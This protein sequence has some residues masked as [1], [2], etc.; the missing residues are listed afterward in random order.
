MPTPPKHRQAIVTAAA[1]L[2]RRRGYAG[3][4]LNDIV[5]RSGAP[6]GSL[7]HYFPAGKAAIGEAAVR[8]AGALVERTLERLAAEAPDAGALMVSYCGWLAHWM[9]QSGWRDGCPIATTLLETAGEEEAIRAAGQAV[10]AGWVE[11]VAGRLVA[12]GHEPEAAGRLAGF[13]VSA[14]EGALLRARVER[15]AGPILEAAEMLGR[16]YRL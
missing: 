9:G 1:T 8:Q 16:L 12:D 4:G 3:T 7:Y 6:K 13:G 2:F 5:A 10:M 11:V 14:L 15:D